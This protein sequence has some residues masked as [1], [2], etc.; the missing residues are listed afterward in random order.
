MADACKHRLKGVMG[1]T[2]QEWVSSDITGNPHSAIVHG[3][4]TRAI[5]NRTVKLQ[6]RYDNEFA[7][8]CRL[9]DLLK[10]L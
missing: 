2:E 1:L 4:A 5:G 10:T 3:L 7:Y 9:L 8:A 6:V